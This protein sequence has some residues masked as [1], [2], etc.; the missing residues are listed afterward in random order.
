MI[1]TYVIYLKHFNLSIEC[2]ILYLNDY[3][4]LIVQTIYMEGQ[5]FYILQIIIH[6]HYNCHVNVLKKTKRQKIPSISSRWLH[7]SH[8]IHSSIFLSHAVYLSEMDDIEDLSELDFKKHRFGITYL[9]VGKKCAAVDVD[10]I[11]SNGYF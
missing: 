2:V 10:R 3:Y 6:V 5:R 11:V 8:M 9:L 4:I 7:R 1:L